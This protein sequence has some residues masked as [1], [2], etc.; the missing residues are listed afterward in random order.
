MA[1]SK[2]CPLSTCFTGCYTSPLGGKKQ[3]SRR[4]HREDRLDERRIQRDQVLSL[5]A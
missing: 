1:C 2:L 4:K 5:N 3:Q